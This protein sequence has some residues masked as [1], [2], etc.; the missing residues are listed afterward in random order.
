MSIADALEEGIHLVFKIN[1]N[2]LFEKA[3]RMISLDQIVVRLA[4]LI[5]GGRFTH[6]EQGEIV[7]LH[8]PGIVLQKSFPSGTEIFRFV[9]TGLLDCQ[10]RFEPSDQYPRT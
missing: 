4:N 5:T 10:F 8:H 3:I 1:Q 9:A 2:L 7:L 6:A